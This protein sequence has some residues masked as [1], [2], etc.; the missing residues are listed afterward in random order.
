MKKSALLAVLFLSLAAL[1]PASAF[2]EDNHNAYVANNLERTVSVID[3]RTDA[4]VA[5][6]SSATFSHPSDM[7]VSPNGKLLYVR[8]ANNTFSV[9][10]TETNTV[11]GT[12]TFGFPVGAPSEGAGPTIA[13][14]RRG[15]RAY[16]A[17]SAGN[18]VVIDVASSSVLQT[19]PAPAGFLPTTVAVS[20]DNDNVYVGSGNGQGILVVDADGDAATTTIAAG[21]TIFDL[22]L[23]PNSER[24]YASDESGLVPSSHLPSGVLVINTDTN[25]V[26]ATVPLPGSPSNPAFVTGLAVTPDGRHVYVEDF[27]LIAGSSTVTVFDTRDNSIDTTINATGLSLTA[28]AISHNGR[29]VFA[30]NTGRTGSSVAVIDTR[31][32]TIDDSITVGRFADTIAIQPSHRQHGDDGDDD[33][34]D[35]DR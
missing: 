6:I 17:N 15:N 28:L 32:N 9:V 7:A 34:G 19:I 1:V 20:R 13:F 18:L 16:F 25:R 2:A 10:D 4:I 30:V 12:I 11:T 26:E 8:N 27:L 29:K 3:T 22:A 24:L 21:H 14:N 5:T 23:S 31:T 35:H 33:H